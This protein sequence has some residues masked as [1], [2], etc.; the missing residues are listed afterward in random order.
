MER[1]E[2][3]GADLWIGDWL[4][5]PQLAR[6]SRSGDAQRVT[7]RS[8]AVLLYLA[9]AAGTVRSRNEIL[10]AVWPGMAV[11]PDALSQCLVELRKVFGDSPKQPGIIE[12]IPKVGVRLVAPVVQRRAPAVQ[13][14]G[15]A[16]TAQVRTE[17][18]RRSLAV[19]PFDN[20]SS[21]PENAY[22]A[23][24]IQEEILTRL[25]R[26]ANHFR[27]ISR[28]SVQRY[29]AHRPPIHAI[30]QELGADVI[31]E[32]SVRGARDKLRVD[33]R[34]VD[35]ATDGVIWSDSYDGERD[36]VLSMQSAVSTDVARALRVELSVAE[37]ETLDRAL[38][39][40]ARAFE[41]YAQANHLYTSVSPNEMLARRLMESAVDADPKF[42]AALG[43]LAATDVL[44]L[45]NTMQGDAVDPAERAQLVRAVRERAHRALEIDPQAI[46]ASGAL[47]R[48][49]FLHW[50]WTEALRAFDVALE[51]APSD[52]HS[53]GSGCWLNALI[54]RR[55][56][57]IR[58]AE[59]GLL[60]NP[61]VG[62]AHRWLGIVHG[63]VGDREAAVASLRTAHQI[64]P[65]DPFSS[66]WL[67]YTEIARGNRV[68]GA[69]LL[70]VTEQLIG[71]SRSMIFLAELALGYARVGR[72]AD[73]RRLFAEIQAV[74]ARRPIGAGSH[75]MASAA[76]GDY[77]EVLRWLGIAAAKV[78][79]HEVDE[80]FVALNN[81]RM[82]ITADPALEQPRIRAALD[83]IRGD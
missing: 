4:V 36:D 67:A 25:S 44:A 1:A 51:T 9:E 11:T 15:E 77:D 6:V 43:W 16:Q 62:E 32:G 28:T 29:A 5:E 31:L 57:A 76:I 41:L 56:R 73:A 35:A 48:V 22:V 74:A 37:R 61:Q 17:T 68:D 2:S 63:V 80:G 78:K 60:L 18:K 79:R 26:L 7:P 58:I 52:L 53:V 71:D 23:A 3:A 47:A 8:M 33:A 83:L 39:G 69:R 13:R 12:T 81:L 21:D 40:S 20:L 45:V 72:G 55:E 70:D 42:A 49:E 82:N 30:A 24:G 19:L 50:R 34:L 14:R 66:A 75:A 65:G 64:A 46:Y 54:G 27:V 10:D 38:T 59:H